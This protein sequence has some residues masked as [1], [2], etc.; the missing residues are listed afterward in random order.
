MNV[1]I[2][3]G[4]GFIGS[5][6]ALKCL[7][8]GDSVR[9]F[10]QENTP[11][12]V[13]N[14][15]LI[16]NRGAE[17]TLG[18]VTDRDK[19]FASVN[20][21]DVV[22]HFAAA[23]HEANVPDQVFW[24]VNAGGTKNILEASEKAGVKCFVHGSTIGVYGSSL[25]GSIDETSP[26]KPDNIYGI[27]KLEGEKLVFSYRKKIPVVIIRISETYGPGDRRLLKLFKAVRK[28][29][30]FMIGN[31]EN[32]HHLIFVDD[33]I[34]G[35]L[36]AAVTEKAAGEIFVLAGKESLTTNDMVRLIA[37]DLGTGGPRFHAPLSPFLMVA[38][39]ME[40]TM[41]PM[42]I[43]P[44]LHRRRMDFFRKSFFFSHQKAS[45]ILGFA[46]KFS[47]KDGVSETAKWYNE[48]GYL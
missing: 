40:K 33:L 41:G 45:D 25:G 11:A 10:G 27:T 9:V 21:V 32:I 20:G 2:T 47:F 17:V 19:V 14:R 39:V 15:Q 7:E 6:L 34:E 28:K 38:T 43:Q 12:E 31:G 36:H 5:R 44:P 8:R 37:E 1:L 42:G 3:G 22:Y 4:T 13:E 18:S 23:Q 48:M 24:D 46:P 35:F 30:F 16:E 29:A 26:L